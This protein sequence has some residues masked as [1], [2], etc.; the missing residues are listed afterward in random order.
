MNESTLTQLKTI[1][2]RTVRPVRAS[3]SHKQKIREELL[4]HV[5]E[6]FEEEL[7]ALDDEQAALKQTVL[8]FGNPGEL[9][10]QLQESVPVSDAI[11]RFLEV[12][13]DEST[14][15]TAVRLGWT[16]EALG[17]IIFVAALIAGVGVNT[18]PREAFVLCGGA[19]LALP[20]YLFG[21]AFLSDWMR[22]SLTGAA[23][24]SW[25]NISLVAVGWW[26][27]SLLV[28]VGPPLLI[29]IWPTSSER[30]V[31]V[32]IAS[33]VGNPLVP[34]CLARSA[35]VRLRDHQQWAT[36]SIDQ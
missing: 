28:L 19:V 16:A 21:L 35:A 15:R 5:S 25:R 2:E 10:G 13:P 20:L 24:R 3:T 1:V 34:Y 23:E 26:L 8:R 27:L 12:K 17:L 29:G 6:V 30:L 14:L 31:A 32:A 4:A 7:A 18:C 22:Q 11:T 36:L 9:R 33:W